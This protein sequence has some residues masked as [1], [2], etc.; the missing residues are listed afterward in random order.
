MTLLTT[1][2]L[3]IGTALLLG[4]AAMACLLI[5][6]RLTE[7]A[8]RFLSF[9]EEP[10]ARQINRLTE[11]SHRA[12]TMV[13]PILATHTVL[14]G[15]SLF[16]MGLWGFFTSRPI[17]PMR[18]LMHAGSPWPVAL[19][20]AVVLL[21][22]VSVL[23]LGP[24]RELGAMLRYPLYRAASLAAL[25]GFATFIALAGFDIMSIL[26][27]AFICSAVSSAAMIGRHA[28]AVYG[29]FGLIW[30]PFALVAASLRIAMIAMIG[31]LGHI[32]PAWMSGRPQ[33]GPFGLSWRRQQKISAGDGGLPRCMVA[34]TIPGAVRPA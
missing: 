14:P 34:D 11:R 17:E 30:M 31:P 29:V 19:L 13:S 23:A 7:V 26:S 15:S 9:W 8:S 6:G 27:L 28:L 12:G 4:H 3:H 21:F 20:G 25:A 32:L 18:A 10:S 33:E 2:A 5:G 24:R 16:L 1:I 22:I